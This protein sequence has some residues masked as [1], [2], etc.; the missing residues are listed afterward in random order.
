M[1]HLRKKSLKKQRGATIIEYALILAAVVAIAVYAFGTDGQSG[2]I[3]T[4]V[5]QKLNNVAND[6]N[7]N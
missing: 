6:L 4:A 3:G 1:I 5:T 7:G 2:T